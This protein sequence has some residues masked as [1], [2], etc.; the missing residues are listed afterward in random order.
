[1]IAIQDGDR[2]VA[3]AAGT[4]ADQVRRDPRLLHCVVGLLGDEDATVVA[5]AAHALMQVAQA[6]PSLFDPHV[7]LLLDFLEQPA[8]WKLESSC[9]KSLCAPH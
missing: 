2:R 5:D 6:E 7:D 1:V 9:R 3:G 4:V 8:Q